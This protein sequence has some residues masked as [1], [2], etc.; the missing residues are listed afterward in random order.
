MNH[1]VEDAAWN[2]EPLSK[3]RLEWSAT[4]NIVQI[5]LERFGT[6]H[7]FAKSAF[8]R[9]AIECRTNSETFAYTYLPIRR[10]PVT[11]QRCT[12]FRKACKL[13]AG[14]KGWKQPLAGEVYS[15]TRNQKLRKVNQG[16]GTDSQVLSGTAHATPSLVGN[17]G[18][19]W[20]IILCSKGCHGV[21]SSLALRIV[22]KVRIVILK[23]KRTVPICTIRFLTLR[24]GWLHV[25]GW[26]EKAL[27][28]VCERIA[29]TSVF[30]L[31][32]NGVGCDERSI[33]TWNIVREAVRQAR[34][35]R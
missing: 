8:W 26:W 18:R 29:I 16:R 23:Y 3:P 17:R 22:G 24:Q 9:V 28:G 15:S 11:P 4:R 32:W 20:Y 1:G 33:E 21:A 34:L 27:Q 31:Q 6:C 5:I 14:N 2:S 12:P 10:G 7:S 35:W 13:E 25:G 30:R 19:G